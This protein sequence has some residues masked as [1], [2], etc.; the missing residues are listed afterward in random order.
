MKKLNF[1]PTGQFNG[2][3]LTVIVEWPA[4]GSR[5]LRRWRLEE[6]LMIRYKNGMLI[7]RGILRCF[8]LWSRRIEISSRNE[9]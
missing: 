5:S 3:L 6:A 1:Y 9:V 8:E 7:A 2:Y 4:K